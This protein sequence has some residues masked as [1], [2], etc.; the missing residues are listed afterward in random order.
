MQQPEF[1]KFMID[2][3]KTSFENTFN[4]IKTMQEQTEKLIT[5]MVEKQ[6]PMPEP[7]KKTILEWVDAMKKSREEFK[8]SMDNN[9]KKLREYFE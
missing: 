7:V 6:S 3:N 5:G 9:Y 4:S 8:A 2:L 1:M